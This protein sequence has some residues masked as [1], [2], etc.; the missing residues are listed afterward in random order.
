NPLGALAIFDRAIWEGPS[1]QLLVPPNPNL[2]RAGGTLHRADTLD[3]L[4]T[5]AG[6]PADALVAT[7]ERYN[8]AL[9]AGDAERLNP[10]RTATMVKPMAIRKPPF[11]AAPACAG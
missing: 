1:R 7:V 5:V 3:E 2:P 10:P 4:A 8:A 9:D 6:L 11:Y